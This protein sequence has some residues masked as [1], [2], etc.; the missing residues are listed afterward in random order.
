[1]P[2]IVSQ[3]GWMQP[4][5][6][7]PAST[8]NIQGWEIFLGYTTSTT[9]IEHFGVIQGVMHETDEET[10]RFAG[11]TRRLAEERRREQRER[12]R[13]ACRRARETLRSLLTEENQRRLD[14]G[15]DL[16]IIGS[17]GG[18]YR[19]RH[20]YQG[21]IRSDGRTFCAHPRMMT[22]DGDWFPVED[23]LIAQIFAL[24]TDEPAFL[25]VANMS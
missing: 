7:T 9:T 23:V 5:V 17:A 6:S 24:V 11:E 25:R 1:M 20:G 15:L 18:Q 22:P 13:A 3:P 10:T 19:V 21:N 2:Y 14:A 8:T 16:L 12:Y 4:A